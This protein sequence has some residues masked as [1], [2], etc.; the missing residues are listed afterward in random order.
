MSAAEALARSHPRKF[1]ITLLEAK[2]Q[3]GGRAGSF[4]D[5]VSGEPVDYC[6]HVAM[7]CCT[8]FLELIG[9][10]QL[11]DSFHRYSALQFLHPDHLP[12]SFAASRWLPPP[13]HLAGT[14]ASLQYLSRSQKNQLRHG[15]WRLMRTK[16]DDLRQRTAADWLA[17]NGQEPSTIRD[18]WDVI[19]VSALGE[20]TQAV[21]MAA[22]RKVFIDGFAAAR[23]ASD[24]LVP[25]VPLSDLFGQRLPQA[26]AALPVDI[27]TSSSVKHLIES[28]T[29]IRLQLAS[30]ESIVTDHVIAAVPWHRIGELLTNTS[31]SAV[32]NLDAFTRFPTSPITGLHLWFDRQIIS[33]PHAVM[34]G[35][36]SQWIFRDPIAA[37]TD[38]ELHYHQ[39]VISASHQARRIPKD[40]LVVQ[41]INEIRH[42]FPAACKANLVRHRIVTDPNSVFSISPEVDAIR[43]AARTA[44]PW[45]HLAGDWIATGW[46]A[47]MEGAVISG[48]MAA[49][50]VL[51]QQGLPPVEIDDGLPRGWLSRVLIK[52]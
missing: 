36:I 45:L 23:G 15:L 37:D 21:T 43:P 40:K 26:M 52:P 11:Q 33:R 5:P 30:G 14:I 9:R 24:L 35:T 6:Q 18:F 42:A 3:T 13:F 51:K 47:T 12:S 28:E 2:R 41:V 32:P 8:N 34:V 46:P 50:S 7:G 20:E 22:A 4:Q 17:A 39:V 49:S 10:C 19:L 48:R 29:E 44:L 25:K 27:L 1:R 31:A 16:T 38:S